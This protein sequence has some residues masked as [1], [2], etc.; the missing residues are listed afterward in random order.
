MK[1]GGRGRSVLARLAFSAPRCLRADRMVPG[2]RRL[3]PPMG[4]SRMPFPKTLLSVP[5]LGLLALVWDASPT[6]RADDRPKIDF[7]GKKVSVLQ[8]FGQTRWGDCSP[9]RIDGTRLYH[10]A[11]VVVDR[12]TKPNPI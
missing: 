7:Y 8:T 10:A 3:C 11:G 12:S 9:G 6:P 2:C 4:A 5:L 1:R